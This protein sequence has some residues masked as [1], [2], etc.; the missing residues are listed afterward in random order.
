MK[1]TEIAQEPDDMVKR[2]GTVN[3]SSPIAAISAIA[4]LG[5]FAPDAGA[6]PRRARQSVELLRQLEQLEKVDRMVR[7][8]EQAHLAAAGAYAM[9]GPTYE[10]AI[11]PDG[12]RYAVS[13]EVPIDVSPVPGDPEATLRKA[14]ALQAAASAPA[15][16]SGQD[17]AVAAQAAQMEARA[18]ADLMR[19]YAEDSTRKGS[20]VNLFA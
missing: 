16:P 17:R 18:Q 7:A 6:S 1:L 19:A 8:H 10:Y 13:G 4:P 14:R 9:G 15:D 12:R 3:V 2:T 20:L 11:G 5:A